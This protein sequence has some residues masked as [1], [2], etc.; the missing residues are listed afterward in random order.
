VRLVV[1][2][3]AG[4]AT[5]A[6]ARAL[7][8]GHA[9]AL[10]VPVIVENLPGASGVVG[11]Q[12]VARSGPNDMTFAVI[13]NSVAILP[14]VMKAFPFDVARDFTPIA[15]LAF[16]PMVVAVNAKVPANNARELIALLK[17]K[18]DALN[19]GSSGAGSIS[20]LTTEMFLDQTG[21]K[22]RHIPFQG[23]SPMTA[24]LLGVQIEFASQGLPVFQPH[25]KGGALR[26][27]GVCSPRRSPVAADIPTFVEQGLPDLLVEAWVT[28]LG[29]RGMDPMLVK[30]VHDAAAQAFATPAARELMTGQGSVIA[31]GGPAEARAT[32]ER[33]MAK[34][35]A[36]VR[37]VGLEPQ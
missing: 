5:D 4:G 12:A 6:T 1:P 21:T 10:G 28:L 36:L 33:D 16:I 8:P 25:F 27:I 35:A 31:L 34:Y 14:S 37:K 11:L 32:I 7:Q 15:M 9:A 24:A 17:Q 29:P 19:F 18:P 20:H 22:A 2:T 30:K 26:A 3:S 13:T 23:P